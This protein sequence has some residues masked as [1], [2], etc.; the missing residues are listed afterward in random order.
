MNA[1]PPEAGLAQAITLY[2]AG[3][4]AEAEALCASLAEA[5]GAHPAVDQ[6]LAVLL[7]ERGDAA[8]A[9]RYIERSLR[10]RPG[11]VPSLLIAALVRQDLRDFNGAEQA[12]A[13]VLQQQPG[14]VAAAVNRGVVLL[15]AGRLDDA[16]ASFAAAYALRPETFG[17]IANALS[18]PS[19]G[20]LW[21]D[22]DDLR[23]TLVAR[24]RG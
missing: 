23:A 6:L 1:M 16:L 2:N 24:R 10:A 3:R 17:R 19:T 8:A 21:L 9:S 7:Q 11:H 20:A 18:T 5:H 4:R 15:E 13:E 12:L 14:H 22:L